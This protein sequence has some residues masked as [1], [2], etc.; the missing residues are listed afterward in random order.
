MIGGSWYG[1]HGRHV[2]KISPGDTGQEFLSYPD[3]QSCERLI[4]RLDDDID[5]IISEISRDQLVSTLVKEYAGLRLMRQDPEQC[6]F[7]FAC[8]SNT[9]I[10]M[11]RMM[12]RNLARKFGD[13]VVV[14]GREFFTFPTA[15]KIHGAT[16]AEI[17][18]CGLGYRVKAVKAVAESIVSGGLDL[19]ALRKAEYEDSKRELLRV[20]GIGN[21]IA[22]CVMLFSLDKLEA[23][24]I[25]VWIARSL[26]KHYKFL[27]DS[28][29]CEKPSPRQ[30][31]ALSDVMRAYFGEYAGY[32]QQYLYYHMRQ[33]ARR[34]W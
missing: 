9:N 10:P 23:F 19:N 24:P 13:R 28:K 26:A 11:I 25:D 31:D 30:Y 20:Y 32:A 21:K 29:F 3:L 27:S 33:K 15:K 6:I 34:K 17:G 16:A 1:I 14:D 4:F 5:R 7:S 12:L 2:I 8:A 22:D 18:A